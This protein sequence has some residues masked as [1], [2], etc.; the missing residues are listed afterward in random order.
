MAS[1][2]LCVSRCVRGDVDGYVFT[3]VEEEALLARWDNDALEV[4]FLGA[5]RGLVYRE[6]IPL[7]DGLGAR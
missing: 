1:S 5:M 4:A 2:T 3:I 7:R 6:R